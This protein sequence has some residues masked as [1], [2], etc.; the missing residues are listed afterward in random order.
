MDV[1]NLK[2]AVQAI[3]FGKHWKNNPVSST[4]KMQSKSFHEEFLECF[5]FLAPNLACSRPQMQ[6]NR[7]K[8][9]TF[10]ESQVPL[11]GAQSFS[12]P[13]NVVFKLSAEA[14]ACALA[15]IIGILTSIFVS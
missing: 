5:E 11:V 2:N 7:S 13:F 4:L 9:K 8:L 15:T 6:R 10:D 1:A 14:I 12:T 3:R